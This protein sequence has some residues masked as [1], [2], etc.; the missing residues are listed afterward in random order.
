MKRALDLSALT[1]AVVYVLLFLTGRAVYLF[2]SQAVSVACPPQPHGHFGHH[3]PHGHRP[4]SHVEPTQTTPL[5]GSFNSTDLGEQHHHMAPP[6][7]T[8]GN[9]HCL[10]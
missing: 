2:S 3:E 7:M 10:L 4:H 8:P 9:M 1:Q 6:P 5:P